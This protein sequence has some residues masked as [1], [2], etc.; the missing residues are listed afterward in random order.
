MLLGPFSPTGPTTF[1]QLAG[2]LLR[3]IGIARDAIGLPLR[4][5]GLLGP[6]PTP[7]T[8]R[9]L[10]EAI[11]E[12]KEAA[13]PDPRDV[14]RELA[15]EFESL[16]QGYAAAGAPFGPHTH[17]AV[18]GDSAH[19]WGTGLRPLLDMV[20]DAGLGLS[21]N[22]GQSRLVPLLITAL[23]DAGQGIHLYE[24]QGELTNVGNFRALE[25][26]E[27][28]EAIAAYNWTLLQTWQSG[29]YIAKEGQADRWD[30]I[31]RKRFANDHYPV[32]LETK[33]YELVDYFMLDDQGPLRKIDKED[34]D[35]IQA[36]SG[37]QP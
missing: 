6:A 15:P 13:D 24:R 23:F 11:K 35:A 7:T 5:P 22:G 8:Y 10:E 21:G 20:T 17:A 33:L 1:A 19:D 3:A 28:T 14:R 9:A 36:I 29:A 30:R 31:L 34:D 27:E 16:V 32:Y 25:M 26:L 18:L 12:L 37:G 4:W 2:E